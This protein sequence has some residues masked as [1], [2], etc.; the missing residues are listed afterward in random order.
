MSPQPVAA[1]RLQSLLLWIILAAAAAVRWWNLDHLP[2]GFHGDEAWTGIDARRVL[3]E[4]WIGPY[5]PAALGQP[6]GPIY[7]VAGLFLFLPDDV[8]TVRLA[9]A[10][11]GLLAVLFTYLAAREYEGPFFAS[12]AAALLAGLLWHLHASRMGMMLVSCTTML[13]AGLWLQA[14]ALR[15]RSPLYALAAGFVAGLGIY[16][17]NAYPTATPLYA[18][19][20]VY[21]FASA[22]R[23]DRVAVVLD[24]VLFVV[25]AVLAALP[26]IS[27]VVAD[28]EGYFRHHRQVSVFVTP[29]W[30]GG[31]WPARLVIL[32]ERLV[33]WL[34]GLFVEGRF[35]AGDGFGVGKIP[36]VDPIT[37]GLAAV[38]ALV[39]LLRWRRP[40]SALTLVAV[41]LISIGAL[42]TD[43]PGAFRR[44][45]A[46]SPFV[47]MLAA[48]TLATAFELAARWSTRR[49]WRM[50]RMAVAVLAAVAVTAAFWLNVQT[51]FGPFVHDRMMRWV[52]A[53][54]LRIASEFLASVPS[55]TRVYFFSERWSC[56]YETRRFLAPD[57]QCVDRSR[58][59]G[60]VSGR[61]GLL[62]FSVKERQPAMIF[63]M[64]E[65]TR[66]L[67]QL[68]KR[69]PEV[70]PVIEKDG[71]EMVYAALYLPEGVA[72]SVG[73]AVAP[74]DRGGPVVPLTDLEPFDVRYDFEAPRIDQA[75]NG[76]PLRIGNQDFAR[77]IG[78][79]APT[80]VTYDVPRGVT[81]IAAT[82]GLPDPFPN[83]EK[84][85]VLFEITSANGRVLA[86]SGVMRP[87]APPHQLTADLTGVRRV[88]LVSGDA[89]DGRDCDH[90]NWGEPV[91]LRP[92]PPVTPTVAA[93]CG[94]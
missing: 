63:L 20:F 17:Y 92:S 65:H 31:D 78:M 10:T 36:L 91:F 94:G 35:D 24:A 80:E 50:P 88:I 27:Y 2:A 55:G 69:H 84:A 59:F 67:D 89:G 3:E 32:Q 28:A 51:Y 38:G 73:V 18:I 45:I 57:I 7:L 14:V 22:R 68:R 54:E 60:Q 83:C 5:V 56:N 64:G 62:D 23:G 12:C 15:R 79:H 16:S 48:T 52:Y 43:G 87:G 93:P 29:K 70:E 25:G 53:P 37:T 41:P 81:S 86:S 90:A 71:D 1:G 49:G 82:V 77:G 9:I 42:L 40:L 11:L 8:W 75:W 44:T 46:L 26:M 74:G 47:V 6:T 58:R 34:E 21:A 76:G 4:G 30:I 33:F 61:S 85:S 19:P 72:R 13:T 39:A 66:H